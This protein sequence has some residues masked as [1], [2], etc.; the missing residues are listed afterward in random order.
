MKTVFFALASLALI[1]FLY[2]QWH[3]P[4]PAPHQ[5]LV[6]VTLVAPALALWSPSGGRHRSGLSPPAPVTS[7]SPVTPPAP[8]PR[9]A[10]PVHFVPPR[11]VPPS[12]VEPRPVPQGALAC[13]VISPFK[14]PSA[15][16][17]FAARMALHV[18]GILEHPVVKKLYRVYLAASTPAQVDALRRAL[19]AAHIRSFYEMHRARDPQG[20]SLGA[21]DALAG[22]FERR[23]R[24]LRAGFHPHLEIRVHR[25]LRIRLEVSTRRPPSRLSLSWKGHPLEATSCP[26]SPA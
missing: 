24:L 4:R 19:T 8:V 10:P 1:L 3:V 18:E 17:R 11:R 14:N 20:L 15:A 6:A 22:A 12:P 13:L 21:Y 5:H 25:S 9:T 2:W 26:G 7:R 16:R 23:V